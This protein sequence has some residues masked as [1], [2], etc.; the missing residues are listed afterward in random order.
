MTNQGVSPA[1]TLLRVLLAVILVLATF[2][3][4]GYSL[5]HWLTSVPLGIT[6]GK[7]LAM[8]L[9]VI[10]WFSCLR[11]A[12]VSLGWFGMGLGAALFAAVVWVLI[13]QG[14]I[15]LS[16]TAIVWLSLVV[17]GIILGVGLSWSLIR[18]RVTG[19]LEV[20]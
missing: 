4:S 15:S 9:L 2:N 3:P 6:P 14:L 8:I 17:L 19:Q 16:G 13:D 11:A 10:G 20:Q 1:G 5:Y 7:V 12:Y 18:A